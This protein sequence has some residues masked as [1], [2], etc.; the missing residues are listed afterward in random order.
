M[1]MS[2]DIEDR[3]GPNGGTSPDMTPEWKNLPGS[4]NA[5]A[6]SMGNYL[7][8]TPM[9]PEAPD[10]PLSDALGKRDIRIVPQ[11]NSRSPLDRAIDDVSDGISIFMPP[12]RKL[13]TDIPFT[14]RKFSDGLF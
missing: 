8:G 3:R 13:G 6:V 5:L 14:Q 4:L 9:I 10:T 1:R 11:I 7:F 2:D 12:G